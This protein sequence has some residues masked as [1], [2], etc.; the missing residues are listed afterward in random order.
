[1]TTALDDIRILPAETEAER[2][3]CYRLAYE[4]FCEEMGTMQESADHARRMVRDEAIGRA[5]LYR[6]M[7]GD[8]VVG[9]L[10]ILW[11]GDGP[12]PPGFVDG[13][14]LDRFLPVVPHA[15]MAITIRFLVKPSHR[16]TAVPLR[17]IVEAARFQVAHGVTLSFC[18]CQ[19]HLLSLYTRLGFRPYAPAFDQPGFGLMVPLVFVVVDREYLRQGHRVLLSVFPEAMADPVLSAQ[20]NALLPNEPPVVSATSLDDAA[21]AEVYGVL[22][23]T[24]ATVGAFDGF[25][26]AELDAFLA[27]SQIIVCQRGQQIIGEGQGT[28]TVYVVLEGAVEVRK[29]GRALTTLREGRVFGE[30]AL[31]LQLK[32]TADV[33]AAADRVRLVALNARTLSRLVESRSEGAAKFL[34]NLSRLLALT[35]LAQG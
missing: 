27:E 8:E 31:L 19:P 21:W 4:I 6:A 30:F 5:R 13:F 16:G 7:V 2:E 18:D 17:L 23:E 14:G 10:G 26:R 24:R 25:T 3:S 34:L 32:R 11:G 9:S 33:Y 1:M 22:S 29:D 12:F 35:V 28:R 15:H 20:V